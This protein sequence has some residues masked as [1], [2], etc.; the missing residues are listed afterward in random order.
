MCAGF[1]WCAALALHVHAALPAKPGPVPPAGSGYGEEE[2]ALL[3]PIESRALDLCRARFSQ[4]G[5]APRVSGSLVAAARELARVAAHGGVDPLGSARLRGALARAR[6]YDPAPTAILVQGRAASA[7]GALA[8]SLPRGPATHVGVGALERDGTVHLVLLAADRRVKLAPFPRDVAAGT[9]AVMSG[10]LRERARPRFFVT[11]PSGLVREAE[12]IAAVSRKVSNAAFRCRLEF[13]EIGRYVVEVLAEG[14]EG[15]EVVALLTV[16]AGGAPLDPPPRA[17]TLR[18]EPLGDAGAE[19]AVLR[20]IDATRHRH[21]LAPLVRAD[22]LAAVA[23][24]H[25]AAMAA[26]GKVAHVLPASGDVG[27]RL[28]RRGIAYRRAYEN[29]ARAGTALGAHES[30]EDSP[31]HLGNVLRP[32]AVRVGV[33]IARGTLPS[34]DPSV[35]LTEIFVEPI[36]DGAASRL[37]PDARVREELWRERAR[38]RLPPLTADAALDALARDAA[39]T[40]RSTDHTEVPDL[41]GRAL[42]LRRGIAAVDV[43]VASA[44]ADATRSANLRDRRFRRVGVGVA[45]GG[46]RRFGSNRLWIAVVYTD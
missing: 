9:S 44:P 36:D 18:D 19:L 28:R 34:G 37:T 21:G 45:T 15:P 29:V 25:S 41:A 42:A 14:D 27:E 38:L 22:D 33:G 3:D 16:S 5:E 31:A 6:S 12:A 35:Y 7:P 23:R 32:D 11:M 1:L 17:P 39:R 10:L 4:G 40:M 20:A 8:G 46:S 43:F 26:A 24:G 2:A 30:A 13:P